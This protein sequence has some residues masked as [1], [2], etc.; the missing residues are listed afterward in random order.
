[1]NGRSRS[2]VLSR[3]GIHVTQGEILLVW[4][5]QEIGAEVLYTTDAAVKWMR[6]DF[7]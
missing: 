6:V 4:N 5:L 2:V 1:M 7:E 3:P